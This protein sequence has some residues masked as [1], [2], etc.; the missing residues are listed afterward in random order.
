VKTRAAILSDFERA[1]PYSQSR[2]LSIEDIELDEPQYGEVLVRIESAGVCHSDL[3]T[4]DGILTKPLPI[5][6]GHEAAGVVEEVGPGVTRVAKGQKIVFSFVPLCGR[7]AA[8]VAGR[9]A[10]CDP[11]GRANLAGTLLRDVRRFHRNGEKIGHHLGVSGFSQYTVAAEESL[12]PVPDDVPL[13]IA[14]VFGCA[15]LTGLGAV[16]RAARVEPGTSVAIFGA[17]GVGLMT[18][19]GAVVAGATRIVVVDPVQAKR[20]VAQQLGATE[21]LDPT[22]GDPSAQLREIAKGGGVDYTF[23][24]SGNA[25]VF[26]NALA[27]TAAGGTMVAVGIPARSA[28]AELAPAP[29]VLGDRTIRGAFMGGAVPLTDIPR[30]VALW[31]AGKLPVERIVSGTI[32]LDGLNE[33][34]DA[35]ANGEALRT[36]VCP[37]AR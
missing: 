4:I 29:F 31:R 23:E 5:V 20:N 34:M 3:S 26:E 25:R 28:K 27:V 18:L 24:C 8:C 13:E 30:Y 10:L 32:G 6:L 12:I 21:V 37:N 22:S 15:A 14:A 7:C 1:R 35:L 36:I 17:G 11:G 2:P 9:P 33:A 16:F 19:L